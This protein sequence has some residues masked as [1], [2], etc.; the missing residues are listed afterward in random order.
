MPEFSISAGGAVA[1]EEVIA[2]YA[3]VGWTT[4]TGEPQVLMRAIRN[5]AFVVTCR[6]VTGELIGL[7][8]AISDDAT[9]CYIQ[10][11]LVKP[12]FQASGAGRAMLEAIQSGYTHVRQTVLITDNAP[13]QRA[14]YEAMG[15][16]EGADFSP[17]PL[18]MFAKFR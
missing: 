9:I 17:E 5:S 11:I 7:A 13:G 1:D 3:S 16:T 18:R 4:Y 12:P 2:L 10:D 14:F 6:S 8:R 15:F